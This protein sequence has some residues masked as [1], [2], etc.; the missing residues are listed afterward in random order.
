MGKIKNTDQ[1]KV[2]ESTILPIV[3]ETQKNKRKY[4]KRTTILPLFLK[5]MQDKIL[6]VKSPYIDAEHHAEGSEEP[7]FVGYQ[8]NQGNIQG[9]RG[10]LHSK[11]K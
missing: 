7:A 3:M 8:G 5:K 11:S 4:R 9:V 1:Y 6:K 10:L 2:Q